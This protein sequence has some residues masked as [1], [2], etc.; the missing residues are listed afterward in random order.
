MFEDQE[1]EE[2]G[3]RVLHKLHSA[4]YGMAP[5]TTPS[6]AAS[7]FMRAVLKGTS[8][9]ARRSYR[10]CLAA[11][12]DAISPSN[13][14]SLYSLALTAGCEYLAIAAAKYTLKM[15]PMVASFDY[16]GL[17]RL[18]EEDL[19]ALLNSDDLRTDNEVVVFNAF[20][21]WVEYDLPNR[22]PGFAH[23]L[24]SLVRLGQMTPNE[25]AFLD[26]HPLVSGDRI[27]VALVAN[28]YLCKLMGVAFEQPY[29]LP[30]SARPRRA[31]KVPTTASTSQQGSLATSDE[32]LPICG[33]PG[34][35]HSSAVETLV[36][37]WMQA[38]Q[39]SNN[40]S[41]ELENAT[42][43]F[44]TLSVDQQTG[45]KSTPLRRQVSKDLSLLECMETT[46]LG[47]GTRAVEADLPVEGLVKDRVT[48]DANVVACGRALFSNIDA[49]AESTLDP[50]MKSHG[51][52]KKSKPSPRT[53]SMTDRHSG[54]PLPKTVKNPALYVGGL[55]LEQLLS[56]SRRAQ[57]GL[58][59]QTQ[60]SEDNQPWVS[61]RTL[62]F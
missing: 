39:R 49:L 34:H 52:M 57:S 27:A 40:N 31:N 43:T 13:A 47:Q 7:V 8:A 45:D 36:C 16:C 33:V 25:L 32:T 22:I 54:N 15:F 62:Q 48:K 5:Y 60:R 12:L 42:S 37:A 4:I 19:T 41:A 17:V 3:A 38:Q 29:G 28:A 11:L 6:N 53:T 10:L 58:P 51:M 61:Q 21:T 50:M 1:P 20:V 18:E 56:P 24:S 46:P 44:D 55:G 23:R 30:L 9:Q 14:L 26:S 35:V 2:G 59:F